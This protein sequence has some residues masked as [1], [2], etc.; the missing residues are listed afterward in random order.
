MAGGSQ[1]PFFPT[2][3]R[4]EFTGGAISAHYSAIFVSSNIAKYQCSTSAGGM[5]PTGRACIDG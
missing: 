1:H 3:D 2:F 4:P 5:L